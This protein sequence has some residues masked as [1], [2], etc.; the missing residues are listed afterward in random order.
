MALPHRVLYVENAIG[1]GGAMI[2]LRHLVRNVDR[3]R[4]SPFVVTGRSGPEYEGMDEESPYRHIPDRLL[5]TVSMKRKLGRRP[6]GGS[7]A[8]LNQS[9]A[10]MD[11]LVNFLPFFAR[12]LFLCSR[13]RPDLIHVNNEPVTNRA[14]ILAGKL[15]HVPVV[16]HVRGPTN[17]ASLTRRLYRLPDHYIPVSHWVSRN[18]GLLGVPASRRTVVYDGIE[19]ENLDVGADGG[20]F[21]EAHGIPPDAF[22]VGL[23]GLLIPWKGQRLFLDAAHRLVE[24]IPNLRMLLVGGTPE[25]CIPYGMELRERVEREGL[26]ESVV[27]TGHIRD[28]PAAYNGLDVV[29]S[30]STSPEPLGTVVIEC[31][32]MGRPLV[33]PD[34]GGA[35]EM[36]DHDRDALLFEHGSAESL[37]AA[38]LRLHRSPA[39]RSRLGAAAREKALDMFAVDRHVRE[40]QM[41]YEHVL[42]SRKKTGAPARLMSADP[43]R[44]TAA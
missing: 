13:F 30:A 22:A 31:M 20:A 41:V 14:A 40:V 34:H 29:V 23:V 2:C 37:A 35:A 10:R 7:R 26:A 4:F 18:I 21:R 16:C 6:G 19:L 27:F 5:D 25:E 1:Y 9:I 33:G 43:V 8:I 42:A 28:M 24:E 17:G 39:L 15:L 3:S 12:L 36:A 38:V 11:D 44:E 32:A